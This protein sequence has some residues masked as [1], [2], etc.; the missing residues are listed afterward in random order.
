MDDYLTP[1]TFIL[2]ITKDDF[3]EH[4]KI[5]EIFNSFCNALLFQ[6]NDAAP[7]VVIQKVL[8]KIGKKSLRAVKVT[9]PIEAM[10]LH[11]EVQDKGLTVRNKTIFPF[12]FHSGF[13]IFPKVTAINV[14]NVLPNTPTASIINDLKL[15]EGITTAGEMKFNTFYTGNFSVFDGTGKMNIIIKSEDQLEQMKTWTRESFLAKDGKRM[16]GMVHQIMNCEHCQKNGEQSRG[17][18]DLWCYKRINE[19]YR[20]TIETVQKTENMTK[21]NAE[22]PLLVH[23]NKRRKVQCDESITTVELHHSEIEVQRKAIEKSTPDLESN[24]PNNEQQNETESQ[25]N[26][27]E[28]DVQN[29]Q[30]QAHADV[31]QPCEDIE[32]IILEGSIET[33]IHKMNEATNLN[34][35]SNNGTQKDENNENANN[36]TKQITKKPISRNPSTSSRD[37]QKGTQYGKKGE[38]KK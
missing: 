3:R 14:E 9:L 30:N 34:S 4:G 25:Q 13:H 32:E 5:T 11:T 35:S 1:L 20:K 10:E 15:P 27:D 22:S 18:D 6:T 37:S 21:Q 33:P 23:G 16:I 7:K 36:N 19:E 24:T 26:T 28:L 38:K 31:T 8:Q 17:H 29:E 2:P 12:Q